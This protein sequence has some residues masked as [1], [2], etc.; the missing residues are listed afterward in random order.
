M[1]EVSIALTDL[2]ANTAS[3]DIR[4]TA[5]TATT[6]DSGNTAVI[7]APGGGYRLI[8]VAENN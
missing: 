3:G 7:A 1:A 4:S 6:V 2:S 5:G 8:V